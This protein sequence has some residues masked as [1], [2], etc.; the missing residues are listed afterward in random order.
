MQT[1]LMIYDGTAAPDADVP[2]T[3]GVPLAPE[4]FAW[5]VCGDHCGGPMQFFAHLPVE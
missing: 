5:P 3:G 2:R 1:T 4:G